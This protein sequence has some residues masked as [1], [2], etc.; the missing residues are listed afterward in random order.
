MKSFNKLTYGYAPV[1][2]SSKAKFANAKFLDPIQSF[3][4]RWT[5]ECQVAF[6]TVIAKLL[7]APMLGF[8]NPKLLYILH[9]HE[10]KTGIG[11]VVYQ[12]ID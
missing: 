3:E 6:N 1:C 2:P 7:S 12:Q 11:A 4:D 8:V 10:G 9:I 5:N